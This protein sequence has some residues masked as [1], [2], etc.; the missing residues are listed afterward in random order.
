MALAGPSS[1]MATAVRAKPTRF[2]LLA[3]FTLAVE[4]AETSNSTDGDPCPAADSACKCASAGVC[5]WL[6]TAGGGGRCMNIGI[7]GQIDCHLC[8]QQEHCAAI[9]CPIFTTACSCANSQGCRWD[10]TSGS[11]VRKIDY[12]TPCSACPAQGHCSVTPPKL[13]SFNPA[14]GGSHASGVDL[15]IAAF[16]DKPV[17][18][19]KNP[20]TTQQDLF[21]WCEGMVRE[22][23]ISRND[24]FFVSTSMRVDMGKILQSLNLNTERTCG[25]F[26]GNGRLCDSTETGYT[27]LAKGSYFFR[28][29]DQEPPV[30]QHYDPSS[31]TEHV[32]LDGWVELL[33]SEPIKLNPSVPKAILHRLDTGQ[34]GQT[35][36]VQSTTFAL[37][38]P[39]AAIV[40][41][42]RLR[43]RMDG[44]LRSGWLYSLEL[45]EGAVLDTANN[46]SV[47][48][49][50]HS[51]KFQAATASLRS[52]S[53][54][55]NSSS[56][57]AAVGLV[58]LGIISSVV[59]VLA[60]GI[61]GVKLY[62]ANAD[63]VAGYLS[64]QIDN[65]KPRQKASVQPTPVQSRPISMDSK[66][67]GPAPTFAAATAAAEAAQRAATAAADRMRQDEPETSRGTGTWA[68]R[69]MPDSKRASA[70]GAAPSAKIHPN[71][72]QGFNAGQKRRSSPGSGPSS[73]G[74]AAGGKATGNSPP[75][76]SSS[77]AAQTME[78]APPEVKA[79]EKRLHGLM[80][81]PLAERKKV[82]KELML[83]FHPDKNSAEHAKEVF[84][85][86]NNSKSWFLHEA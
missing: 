25:L 80:D 46:P 24:V 50:L 64:S 42:S 14:H 15:Q 2:L 45:P 70:G 29:A 7:Q 41:A 16:F 53:S 39:T 10:V 38:E 34:T 74:A 81:K 32:S 55:S 13:V 35:V 6:A 79:V 67:P 8:S 56:G 51:F 58:I 78:S 11:C 31:L 62:K 63:R 28:L 18:W 27:G 30:L 75:P 12:G 9:N 33:Y 82:M 4:T 5:A 22:Y 26:I 21:F 52:I 49:P 59:C 37:Q 83:E 57:G 76:S 73:D 1:S 48:L 72:G 65:V 47:S 68:S 71:A 77:P 36:A 20:Y 84:Q 61:G 54:S 19:C 86:V 85:Y 44:K 3:L 17:T 69:P 66:S 40:S 23:D 60:V 43:V